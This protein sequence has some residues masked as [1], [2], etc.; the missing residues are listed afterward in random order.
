MPQSPCSGVSAI[1]LAAG[2]STRMGTP[3]PLVRVGGQAMLQRVLS[4]LHESQVDEIIVVLGHC[5][6]LIRDSVSFGRAKPILN[7]SYRQG[8]ASS[9][10]VGLSNVSSAAQAALIVLADQPFLKPLTISVL[11]DA[12]R[13]HNAEIVVPVH[14]GFRGNP[15][16][17]SRAV[18]AEVFALTGDVG[19]RAIFAT[20]PVGTLKVPVDDA[21]ILTDLDTPADVQRVQFPEAATP[22]IADIAE[23]T[24]REVTDP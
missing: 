3:K 10:Q 8:M 19:F 21:G 9:I 4:T 14:K 23:L 11:I 2:S 20:H 15:V 5:A 6:Q 7:E 16:L 24:G 1:V 18:F 12:Y 13:L 17:L 22:D